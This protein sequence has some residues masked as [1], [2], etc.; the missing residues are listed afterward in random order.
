VVA[1]LHD[2]EVVRRVFPKTLLIARTPVAWGDTA[3]VLKPA[4]LLQARRMIEAFDAR[5][6]VCEQEVA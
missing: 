6:H 5:A 2:L 4:N 1:V 3:D